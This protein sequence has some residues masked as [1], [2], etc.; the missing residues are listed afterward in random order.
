MA[1]FVVGFWLV[2]GLVF[3]GIVVGLGSWWLVCGGGV[4]ERMVVVWKCGKQ[5][6]REI[7]IRN[8]W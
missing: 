2:Y 3:A 7:E 5:N 8:K 4:D 1:G 6:D